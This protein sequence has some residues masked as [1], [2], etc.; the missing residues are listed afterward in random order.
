MAYVGGFF[1]RWICRVTCSI[2]VSSTVAG[3]PLA[4]LDVLSSGV[5]KA[6]LP[7]LPHAITRDNQEAH[8]LGERRC[9]STPKLGVAGGNDKGCLVWKDEKN[10]CFWGGEQR[11]RRREGGGQQSSNVHRQNRICTEWTEVESKMRGKLRNGRRGAG[12]IYLAYLETSTPHYGHPRVKV[13][14]LPWRGWGYGRGRG[15]RTR[16]DVRCGVG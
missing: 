4:I 7:D 11:R 2:I 9:S 8:V 1:A 6:S 14:Q 12:A 5:S 13:Q 10:V 16:R 15:R 3:D